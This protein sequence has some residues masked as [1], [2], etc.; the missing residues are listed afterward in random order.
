MAVS[1]SVVGH[2]KLD[3]ASVVSTNHLLCRPRDQPLPQPQ[4]RVSRKPQ[5]HYTF[6][7][8]QPKSL[9]DNLDLR[10]CRDRGNSGWQPGSFLTS[11]SSD[12]ATQSSTRFVNKRQTRVKRL[13]RTVSRTSAATRFTDLAERRQNPPFST[14]AELSSPIKSLP[15]ATRFIAQR[16]M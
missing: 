7:Q 5:N 13:I 1:S 8:E 6:V 3:N 9:S 15:R 14:L 12:V 11:P 2:R 4:R 16:V 10:L